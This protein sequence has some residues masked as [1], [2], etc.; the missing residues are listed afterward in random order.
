MVEEKA[1]RPRWM[2]WLVEG[3]LLVLILFGV[4][5]WQARHLPRGE[6]PALKGTLLDGTS[7]DLEAYRGEP[8]LVHFWA[9]WCPVCRLEEGSIDDLARD[10]PVVTIATTS[11][12][13]AQLKAYLEKQELSFPVLPDESGLIG[14]EW[15]I[16]GVPVSF[17]LDREGRIRFVVAGYATEIG[18]R[19]RLW[20]AGL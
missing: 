5:Q 2:R 12:E 16:A 10:W 4:Q 13:R 14:R 18:L 7:V 1:G 15:G 9:T 8:L 20:W 11:G 6:A 17:V 19:A 3:L